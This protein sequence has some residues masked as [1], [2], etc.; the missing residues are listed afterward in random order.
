MLATLKTDP[1]ALA[2]D[3]DAW[4][5]FIQVGELQPDTKA[6]EQTL[7]IDTVNVCCEQTLLIE[8]VLVHKSCMLI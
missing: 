2:G 3:F 4:I 1:T 5:E 6:C 8:T 7:Q